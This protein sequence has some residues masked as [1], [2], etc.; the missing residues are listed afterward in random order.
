[1]PPEKK[2]LDKEAIQEI[3]DR[4]NEPREAECAI[5]GHKILMKAAS[6]SVMKKL[7][8]MTSSFQKDMAEMPE[9]E[10]TDRV[11]L[12]A[13][14]HVR[15]DR[16]A[17]LLISAARELLKHYGVNKTVEELEEYPMSDLEDFLKLQFVLNGEDDFLS[18]PLR[19]ILQIWFGDFRTPMAVVEEKTTAT[20]L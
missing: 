2:Q 19:T 7:R 15:E 18:R 20:N 1:M 6:I 10:D 4:I 5:V 8:K 17:D 3:T 12:Y 13:R 11:A 16:T 14:A 9:I